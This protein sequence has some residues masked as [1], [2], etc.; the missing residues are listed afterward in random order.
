M[1]RLVLSVQGQEYCRTTELLCWTCARKEACEHCTENV[2]ML[3]DG[4]WRGEKI[5]PVGWVTYSTTPTAA[6]SGYGAGWWLGY[7]GDPSVSD[8]AMV[9][10]APYP[11]VQPLALVSQHM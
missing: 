3:Q 5:L 2:V 8:P 6:F 1:S 11:N 9:T 4:V 7:P 10:T